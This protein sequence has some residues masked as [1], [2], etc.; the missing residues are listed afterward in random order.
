MELA[1]TVSLALKRVMCRFLL[2]FPLAD[3]SHENLD[4]VAVAML[5]YILCF[6]R[7]DYILVFE[8]IFMFIELVTL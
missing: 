2:W 7:N 1:L 8:L 5:L 3:K 4:F 6:N